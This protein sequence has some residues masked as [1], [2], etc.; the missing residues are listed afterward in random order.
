MKHSIDAKDVASQANGNWH[1]ILTALGIP[2]E[3][4][5]NKHKPCP[6]C[7]GKDRF[8]FDNKQ[9]KGTFI[10]T[11]WGNGGGDGFALVQHYFNCGF[12]EALKHVAGVLGMTEANPLPTHQTPPQAPQK[13]Q[14]DH[15]EALTQIWETA[16]QARDIA[17]VKTYLNRRGLDTEKLGDT[18]DYLRFIPSMD[19]WNFDNNGKPYRVGKYPVMLAKFESVDGELMGLH[20]TYLN[21]DCTS[22]AHIVDADTGHALDVKK[23]AA[24]Y[25]SS[26][27]GSAIHLGHVVDELAI[28]EGIETALAVHELTGLPVWA[29]GNAGNMGNMTFPQ[30]LK[31]LHIYADTDAN[32]TGMNN[33]RKLE[34]K[35]ISSGIEVRIFET[36]IVGMDVLDLL[37]ASKA[38]KA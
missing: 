16:K 37:V 26:T 25:P 15:I 21:Q 7:G 1:Y 4:L 10:C 32:H 27:K 11:H 38:V 13:P 28:A 35:A 36:G 34:S 6:C 5:T 8:R 2:D 18:L 30:G 3:A 31:R 12:G 33:A 29:C 17:Q 9:G 24:R 23:M 20:R 14:A 22:K 19:Y